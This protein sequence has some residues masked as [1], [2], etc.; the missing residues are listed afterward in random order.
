MILPCLQKSSMYPVVPNMVDLQLKDPTTDT[1]GHIPS[2]CTIAVLPVIHLGRLV[3]GKD[4][5]VQNLTVLLLP[6][7]GK[8]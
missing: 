1:P 3:P 6:G 8:T 4:R 5:T 7:N 2:G